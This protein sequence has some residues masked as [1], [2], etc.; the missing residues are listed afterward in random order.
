MLALRTL[1]SPTLMSFGVN[2]ILGLN[3]PRTLLFPTL[4]SCGVGLTPGLNVLV[5]H[6]R[7]SGSLSGPKTVLL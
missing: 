7:L 5:P 6:L 3:V 4:M 1:L 2:P